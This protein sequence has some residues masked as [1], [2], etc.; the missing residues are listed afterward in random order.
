MYLAGWQGEE[1]RSG[2]KGGETEGRREM[3]MISRA[4]IAYTG[5]LLPGAGPD[6]N[7]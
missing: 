5:I 2:K 3:R 6:P 7:G 4:M 1:K